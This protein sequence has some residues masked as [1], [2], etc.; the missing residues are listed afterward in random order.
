MNKA[1]T[2]KETRK[3]LRLR[4]SP[5]GCLLL[6]LGPGLPPGS[7]SGSALAKTCGFCR[8]SELVQ[9]DRVN[10][11]FGCK[12][13]VRVP[14]KGNLIQQEWKHQKTIQAIKILNEIVLQV[15]LLK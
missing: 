13:C 8:I 3:N 2:Q 1:D 4:L 14:L 11:P 5:Q 9:Q 6:D 12:K 10:L 15:P 7:E